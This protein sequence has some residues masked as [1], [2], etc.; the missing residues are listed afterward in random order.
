[1]QTRHRIPTIFNLSMVDVLCCALGCVI[2]LWLLNLRE[3]KQRADAAGESDRLLLATRT[4]LE[5]S[6]ETAAQTQARLDKARQERDQ[7]RRELADV[8]ARRDE[9]AREVSALQAERAAVL[10]RLA[11]LTRDYGDLSRARA[12]ATQR[13]GALESMLRDKETLAS[14][15]ARRAEA[16]AERLLEA[17]NR[18]KQMQLLADLVPGLRSEVQAARSKL[19]VAEARAQALEAELGERKKALA[20]A[21]QRVAVLQ[22]EKKSLTDQA[23][24]ARAAAD[25]RFAGIALTGRRVVF[26]VDMSGSMD[27]V[28]ERTP[29]AAKWAGVRETL[30]KLLRSL[31]ELEKFQVLLFSDSVS[32]P[33]GSDDRWIDFDPKTSVERVL[34]ALAAVQPRGNTNM[35]AALETAFRLRGSGLDTIYLLSDGLPNIGQGLPA[36]TART[37]E[38]TKRAELL[39]KHVRST[40]KGSWNRAIQGQPRVRINTIGFFYESPDVGAFLWALARENDGSF[41][42]MS[43]P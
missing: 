17:E 20:D 2:L 19:A 9:L 34:K 29:D 31:P 21:G 26:I 42:G 28:D 5:Q 27:L 16:L 25:T 35:Y 14:E 15:T 13:A 23:Q 1:M 6:R 24:R 12:D 40:L 43:R 30:T 8:Q 36:Q 32:Y 18:L 4:E 37:L 10:E 39:A 3:V 11:K 7:V 41:V 38:E 22:D 33:L